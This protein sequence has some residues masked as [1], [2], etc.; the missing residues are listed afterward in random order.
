M[1]LLA[2]KCWLTSLQ[3]RTFLGMRSQ[4]RVR[5]PAVCPPPLS[6]P[7][8]RDLRFRQWGGR[9]LGKWLPLADFRAAEFSGRGFGSFYRFR[10]ITPAC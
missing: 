5:R 6:E 3:P 7:Q 4:R 1:R 2:K 9:I 8:L 10:R